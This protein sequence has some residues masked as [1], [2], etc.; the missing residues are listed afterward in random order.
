ME[1]LQGLRLNMLGRSFDPFDFLAYAAGGFLA[2]LVERQALAR[3]GFW[4]PPTPTPRVRIDDPSEKQ[5]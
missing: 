1:L 4:T 3:L 5:D 2:A